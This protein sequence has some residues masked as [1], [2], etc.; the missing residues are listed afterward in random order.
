MSNGP[1]RQ[2]DSHPPRARPP[3]GAD[4]L[5]TAARHFRRLSN[6]T[7]R[8]GRMIAI[9]T[10]ERIDPGY[11]PARLSFG[12]HERVSQRLPYPRTNPPWAVPLKP[13]LGS[14]GPNRA[15]AGSRCFDVTHQV[16]GRAA[17][18]ARHRRGHIVSPGGWR[19]AAKWRSFYRPGGGDGELQSCPRGARRGR[20]RG[21]RPS[22]A[23]HLW[24]VRERMIPTNPVRR[25]LLHG[26]SE[27]ARVCGVA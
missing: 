17:K 21:S 5:Q 10:E 3:N 18:R 23:E 26:R 13:H 19:L 11:S 12:S 16:R 1:Q 27:S 20:R 8:R 7:R 6:E 24:A 2:S 25:L 14:A 9:A 22:D 4:Q 15:G